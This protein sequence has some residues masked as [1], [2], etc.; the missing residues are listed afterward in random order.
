MSRRTTARKDV[1]RLTNRHQ[2]NA[3]RRRTRT[4]SCGTSIEPLERRTLLAAVFVNFQPAASIVSPPAGYLVDRGE[5]EYTHAGYNYPYGWSSD[6]TATA[7]YLTDADEAT[8][9]SNVRSQTF[10]TMG[11]SSWRIGLPNGTYQVRAVI[12]N[13][14]AGVPTS[15]PTYKLDIQGQRAIDGLGSPFAEGTKVVTINGGTQGYG[16]LQLSNPGT[17]DNPLAYVQIFSQSEITSAPWQPSDL[18]ATRTAGG[19]GAAVDLRWRDNSAV[20]AA[21][22]E[23]EF[24]I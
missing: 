7:T 19:N 21:D 13:A 10:V 5:P 6:R 14:N 22:A 8:F 23:S 24:I 17:A 15:P 18:S 16:F 3:G 20:E 4:R 11:T 1:T 12:G 2:S 9:D